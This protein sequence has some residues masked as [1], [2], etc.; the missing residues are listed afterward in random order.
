MNI[1]ITGGSGF[2]GSRLVDELSYNDEHRV[3]V[4]DKVDNGINSD[5]L[6]KGDIRD[7]DAIKRSCQNIDIIYHLAAEHA[8]NISPIS[9]YEDVNIGGAK[10]VVAAAK[11]NEIKNIIFTSSVAIYGLDQDRPDET[12]TPNPFNEYGRTKYEAEKIFL[13]WAKEDPLNSLTIIRPAVVFGEGNKGNVYNMMR[14]IRSGRFVI[15][16]DGHNKKSM[17]YVGNLS[18]LLTSLINVKP[19]IEIYNFAG[20]PDLSSKEIV[21]IVAD[22]MGYKKKIPNAPKWFGLL[23]GFIYDI[24][25]KVTGKKYAISLIRIKKF[26]SDT[27]VN[28]EHLYNSRFIEKYSLEEGLRRMIKDCKH[29]KD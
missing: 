27:T 3:I 29:N 11:A 13:Q 10:N 25:S 7:Q 20:R 4:F 24:F 17:G 26:I 6:I 9:L 18:I 16:G 12:M 23:V 5:I 28:T 21:S 8:D 22:E 19:G 1:M 15:I 2:I 14:Q